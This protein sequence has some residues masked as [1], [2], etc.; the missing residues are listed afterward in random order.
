MSSGMAYD[1]DA[2]YGLCGS[3]TSLLH[4]TANL[5]SADAAI[6]LGTTVDR[7]KEVLITH[8][9]LEENKQAFSAAGSLLSL[10]AEDTCPRALFEE[11][12]PKLDAL[13]K[14]K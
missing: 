4:G 2:A 9:R 8:S 5:T 13:L 6:E 12:Y 7:L 1:S 14:G 10:V 11:Q 3:I